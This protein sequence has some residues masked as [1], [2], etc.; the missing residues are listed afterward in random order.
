MSVNLGHV[1]SSVHKG[2]RL[3]AYASGI[4]Q[5][6]LLHSNLA[7]SNLLWFVKKPGYQTRSHLPLKYTKIVTLQSEHGL[8]A[9]SAY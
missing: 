6:L 5:T 7:N 4:G 9:K 8:F 1:H 2:K 3:V